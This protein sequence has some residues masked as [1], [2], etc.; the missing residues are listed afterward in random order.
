VPPS[1]R[2]PTGGQ[3][4]VGGTGAE[5][6]E[7]PTLTFADVAGLTGAKEAL[8]EAVIM[9]IRLPRMFTGPTTPWK[10]ILMYGPPGTGKSFLARALAGE[11]GD[12]TFLT[13]STSD[14]LSKWLGESEKAVRSLFEEARKKRPSII[15][16]DE[17]ES[18][19]GSRE[20][21]SSSSN[22]MQG[23]KTEFLVQLDG[24]KADNR[25][26][27]MIAATNLPW[28]IDS[29]MRRRFEKRIYIPLPDLETRGQLLDQ[30][31]KGGVFSLN[32][33]E[34][35]R[36]INRT[37]GFSGA[38][39]SILV[40]EALMAPIRELQ[41]A[42]FFRKNRARDENGVVR[43]GLW[44]V[45]SQSSP[46]SVQTT[47]DQLPPS[48]LAMPVAVFHHFEDALKKTKPSVDRNDLVKYETWTREFGEEGS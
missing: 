15:F 1:P 11:A 41:K 31:L 25:G 14:L 20:S 36:I 44:V 34:K 32:A 7:R 27:L 5:P 48:D 24:V 43:D 37:E 45:C 42:T 9:P 6:T 35:R 30:K 23:V 12:V 21:S 2:Q 13:V 19:V 16:I 40:R 28:Q 33:D 38:D 10:G 39:M 22:A 4:E 8:S 46:G 3:P 47:W 17:I 29:A 26:V 18:L